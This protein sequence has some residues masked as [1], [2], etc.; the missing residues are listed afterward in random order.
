MSFAEDLEHLNK[1]SRI[2]EGQEKGKVTIGQA[3]QVLVRAALNFEHR[4]RAMERAMKG[5][6]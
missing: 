6:R 2:S 1:I 4:L 3:V 5:K